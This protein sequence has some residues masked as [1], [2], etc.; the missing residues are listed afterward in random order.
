MFH[1]SDT[2]S[3]TP[4]KN[5]RQCNTYSQVNQVERAIESQNKTNDLLQTLIDQHKDI[6][7]EIKKISSVLNN[8]KRIATA[9]KSNAHLARLTRTQSIAATESHCVCIVFSHSIDARL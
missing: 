2:L 9:L 4:Q 1:D 5:K 3:D 6:L 7:A 8:K